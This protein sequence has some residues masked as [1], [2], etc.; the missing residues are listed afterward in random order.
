MYYYTSRLCDYDDYYY[1]YIYFLLV[2]LA[3]VMIAALIEGFVDWLLFATSFMSWS[4]I[5]P[6]SLVKW[7]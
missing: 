7:T 3:V 6:K 1:Y 4:L 2:L 5:D